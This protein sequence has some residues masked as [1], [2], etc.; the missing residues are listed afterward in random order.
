MYQNFQNKKA[1]TNPALLKR[2][3]HSGR[4]TRCNYTKFRNAALAVRK[5]SFGRWSWPQRF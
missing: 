4:Q 1:G 3:K 5:K 2:N